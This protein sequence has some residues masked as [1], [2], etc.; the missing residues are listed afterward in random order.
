MASTPQSSTSVALL[1]GRS[2]IAALFL[3]SG[4]LK[5]ADPAATKEFIV[6]T[7]IPAPTL[8]YICAL[9][10]ELGGGML[11][12]LGYR[13]RPIALALAAYCVITALIFHHDISGQNQLF[14]FL[15]NIGIAGGLL[16]LF[17]SG[18]GGYSLDSLRATAEQAY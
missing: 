13:A 1:V 7:G 11:L 6:A 10:I 16:F 12:L 17:E 3:V 15:K 8:A 18:A 2:L 9:L 5:V 14:H 4:A